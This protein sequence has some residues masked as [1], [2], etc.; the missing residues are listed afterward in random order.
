[1]NIIPTQQTSVEYELVFAK[2]KSLLC[3]SLLFFPPRSG[4]VRFQLGCSSRLLQSISGDAPQNPADNLAEYPGGQP[5]RIPQSR[6]LPCPCPQNPV[7]N[8]WS[9]LPTDFLRI[10]SS[11]SPKRAFRRGKEPA[12]FCLVCMYVGISHSVFNFLKLYFRYFM[13]PAF[14]VGLL[15]S[16]P[17]VLLASPLRESRTACRVC[18][19]FPHQPQK[20]PPRAQPSIVGA[21]ANPARESRREFL[22]CPQIQ[23]LPESPAAKGMAPG[24]GMLGFP[25]KFAGLGCSASPGSVFRICFDSPRLPFAWQSAVSRESALAENQIRQAG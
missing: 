3:L 6:R 23:R 10:S 17:T 15:D 12:F 25:V 20:N 14:G 11:D 5:T 9:A 13:V 7:E 16:K 1:M 8:R 2:Y 4:A 22:E 18:G 19:E 24:L 21:P